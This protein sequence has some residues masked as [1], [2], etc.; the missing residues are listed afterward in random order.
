MTISTVLAAAYN[1]E[2]FESTAMGVLGLLVTVS[3]VYQTDL[4]TSTDAELR[5]QVLPK[6]WTEVYVY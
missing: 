3:A 5:R 6:Q 1:Q 2:Q 4:A